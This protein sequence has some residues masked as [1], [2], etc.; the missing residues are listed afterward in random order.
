[1]WQGAVR[2][3]L[4]GAGHAHQPGQGGRRAGRPA[5]RRRLGRLHGG[6]SAHGKGLSYCQAL[7]RYLAGIQK[8]SLVVPSML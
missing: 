1:M 7:S 6:P 5:D 4:C 3:Q 8:A 2:V